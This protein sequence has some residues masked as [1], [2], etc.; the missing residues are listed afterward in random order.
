MA[1]LTPF[2]DN[3]MNTIR[4]KD[5]KNA[6]EEGEKLD[7]ATAFETQSLDLLERGWW[8]LQKYQGS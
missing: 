4:D 1:Y 6:T 3:S 7:N 2:T 8:P 5:D